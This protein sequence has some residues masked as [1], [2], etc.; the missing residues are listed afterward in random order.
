MFSE[1]ILDFSHIKQA[2]QAHC[3]STLAKEY[4]L[5]IK[6]MQNKDK[7][8]EVL[9]ETVEAIQSLSLIHI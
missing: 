7:I 5:H 8:Q 3:S 1:D 9:N 2:L 6:P 4:A